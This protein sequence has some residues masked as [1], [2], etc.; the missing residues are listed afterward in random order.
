MSDKNAHVINKPKLQ[1][2]KKEQKK[3]KF[4]GLNASPGSI[5]TW[6]LGAI[7]FIFMITIY[8]HFE[9]ARHIENPDDKIM[10]KVS[11]MRDSMKE[12]ILEKDVRTEKYIFY[13]DTVASM[14]RL[15]LGVLLSTII[16]LLVGLNM[17]MFKGLDSLLNPMVRVISI[18]PPLALLPI[19]F[20]TLGVE[21]LGKVALIFIGTVP[22]I[23]RS[24]YEDT[25]KIPVEQRTK[26][27]TL[28]ASQLQVVYTIVLPQIMPRLIDSV[29]LIC[30]SAWLFLISAEAISATEGLGYRIFLV[31]RYLA[32]DVII[33]Y[34]LWITALGFLIDFVLRKII[35][36]KYS[37]YSAN[38]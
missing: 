28:N 8:T 10:P 12:L 30:G 32:M 2:D 22:T 16:G 25:I 7:P 23:I 24:V 13:T 17:G 1:L 14:T 19:L 3:P 26:A 29:R 6:I 4:W 33:P 31:R 20:I 11:Q 34:A 27:L 21:E 15:G 5:L 37:W 35:E 36:K 9:Q 18:I 38:K